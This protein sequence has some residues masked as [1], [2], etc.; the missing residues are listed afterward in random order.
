MADNNQPKFLIYAPADV[1]GLA[2]HVNYQVRELV[3]RDVDAVVLAKK[4]FL[5]H[6]EPEYTVKRALIGSVAV[7]NRY[8]RGVLNILVDIT[9]FYI[10]ALA[11][12][13]RRPSVVL[14]DS[15]V[16]YFSLFW[17]WPHWLLSRVFGITYVANLHDPIRDFRIGPVWFHNLSNHLAFSIFDILLV[18]ED[19]PAECKI[20]DRAVV[21]KVP[22]GIYE[23]AQE[24]EEGEKFECPIDVP[25]GSKL[26]LSYGFL[27]DNKNLDLFLKAMSRH[28]NA[29][30][31][32]AGRNQS[33]KDK[34]MQF[35]EQLARELQVEDRVAFDEGFVS[36]EK[37][38][39][40]FSLSDYIVLTYDKTFVSQSGVL[41]IAANYRKPV[42]AS[43][44]DSPLKKCVEDFSLG[45]FCE[46]DSLD[47]LSD[48]LG[49]MVSR[50]GH[51]SP[52]WDAYASF[53]SWGANIDILLTTLKNESV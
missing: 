5:K 14:F 20:P 18:H 21:I 13:F 33:E 43:S 31:L 49:K 7:R 11:V 25:N 48:G 39:Y 27:R 32:V 6:R 38:D 24:D 26:F 30:L 45:V 16:E 52:D 37:T 9:N 51:L 35:Y 46:P 47:G 3:R 19:L 36:D 44:G 4:S 53:A 28:P 40:Y 1:G 22:V 8:V 23:T 29:Y 42:L 10:L 41:N 12:A 34:D 2:E 50:D 15:Y 17:F